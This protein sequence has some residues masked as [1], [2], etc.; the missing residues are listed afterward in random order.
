MSS[1]SSLLPLLLFSSA[2][3]IFCLTLTLLILGYR[4]KT[5]TNH[6]PSLAFAQI[7]RIT[8]GSN[9][10]HNEGSR[11]RHSGFL[12]FS[13]GQHGGSN[14]WRWGWIRRQMRWWQD[15]WCML[16]GQN[17]LLIKALIFTWRGLANILVKG[18][19]LSC[20]G[21]RR[22]WHRWRRRLKQRRE[23]EP[24]RWVYR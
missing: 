7:S 3:C 5:L 24:A 22:D 20:T 12:P 15:R 14:F 9:C 11:R 23:V 1:L 6:R 4:T 2:C 17:R 8:F 19:W 21:R 13:W 10:R 16:W 18:H